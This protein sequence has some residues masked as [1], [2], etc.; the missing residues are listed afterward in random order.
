[1]RSTPL[2]IRPQ[3]KLAGQSGISLP[4]LA[5]TGCGFARRTCGQGISAVGTVEELPAS[6]S[7][8]GIKTCSGLAEES[9]SRLQPPGNDPGA[10]RAAGPCSHDVRKGQPL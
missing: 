5:G 1:M 3:P 7:D 6:G 4:A 8:C 2:R 10:Y 9:A